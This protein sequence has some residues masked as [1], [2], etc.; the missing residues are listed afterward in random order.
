MNN[1]DVAHYAI[2]A[3]IAVALAGVFVWLHRDV[4]TEVQTHTEIHSFGFAPR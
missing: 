2:A 3:L 4:Q 1:H